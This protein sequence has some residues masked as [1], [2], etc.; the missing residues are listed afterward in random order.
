MAGKSIYAQQKQWSLW[1]KNPSAEQIMQDRT[2]AK[3][4]PLMYQNLEK[5]DRIRAECDITGEIITEQYRRNRQTKKYAES[6]SQTEMLL[7]AIF[8]VFIACLLM[9]YICRSFL[10]M[11]QITVLALLHGG[12]LGFIL[13]LFCEGLI[14]CFFRWL[15]EED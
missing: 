4:F 5:A 1:G 9:L 11:P 13:F 12:M 15:G 3:L 8:C 10:D 6:L 2:K 7:L 14:A